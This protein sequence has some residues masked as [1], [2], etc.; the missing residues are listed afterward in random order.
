MFNP[1][2]SKAMKIGERS[3][4]WGERTYIMGILNITTDSF[5]GDG[6]LASGDPLEAAL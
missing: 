3:F 1:T 4:V 6:L 2:K 5:S